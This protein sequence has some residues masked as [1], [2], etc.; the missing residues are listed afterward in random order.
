MKLRQTP[1]CLGYSKRFKENNI[2][3]CTIHLKN[4][5]ISQVNELI[6]DALPGLTKTSQLATLVHQKTEGNVFFVRA[7][8]QTLYEQQLLPFKLSA[9]TESLA[10]IRRFS[11]TTNVIDILVDKVQI[12]PLATQEIL[13]LAACISTHFDLATL[14]IIAEATPQQVSQALKP[15]LIADI[16]STRWSGRR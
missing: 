3:I 2:G 16:L 4:L 1:F 10:A 9:A 13:K 5:P 12:L 15:A 11:A 14:A 6:S 8:L 7:F